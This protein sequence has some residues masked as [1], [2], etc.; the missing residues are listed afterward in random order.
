MDKDLEFE[1]FCLELLD[2]IIGQVAVD[3]NIPVEVLRAPISKAYVANTFK[4]IR[5]DCQVKYRQPR[6]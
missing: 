6:R 2:A 5:E 1:R 3:H 4:N